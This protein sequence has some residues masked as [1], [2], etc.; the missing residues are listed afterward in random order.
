MFDQVTADESGAAGDECEHD[1]SLA[2]FSGRGGSAI[3][4]Q[5]W[6]GAGHDA[7]NEGA[8]TNPTPG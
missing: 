8:A 7:K 6:A 5:E 4:S 2:F 3:V 1:R